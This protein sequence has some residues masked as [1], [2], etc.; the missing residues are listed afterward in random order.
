[1]IIEDRSKMLIFK[2]GFLPSFDSAKRAEDAA[3]IAEAAS[4]DAQGATLFAANIPA[5]AANASPAYTTGTLFLT[6]QE[7][8]AM[9]VLAPSDPR[10][11]L[12]TAGGVK[13]AVERWERDDRGALAQIGRRAMNGE[14]I[15]IAMYG[16]STV[17]GPPADVAMRWPERVGSIMRVVTKNTSIATYN[18]GVS[19]Q[20]LIDWWAFDNFQALVVDPYPLSE[21]V[22]IDFGLND[23]KTDGTGWDPALFKERYLYLINQVRLSGRIPIVM[24]PLMISGTLIRPVGVMQGELLNTVKELAELAKVDLVDFNDA[25]QAW[26]KN[27][28]DQHRIAEI[29]QDGTHGQN[30]LYDVLAQVVVRAMYQHM[31]VD[32]EHGTQLGQHNASFSAGFSVAF[33]RTINNAF[34]MSATL[35]KTAGDP[36]EATIMVWS[37]RARHAVYVS[38]DRSVVGAAP[39]PAVYVSNPGISPSPGGTV[40]FGAAGT[41]TADRP[42]E[43]MQYVAEL[44]FG[45]SLLRFRA[46]GAG[47]YEFGGWLIVDQFDSVSVAAYSAEATARQL[48]LP[49]F[50]DSRPEIVARRSAG[51]HLALVGDLPVGWGVVIGTQYVFANDSDTGPSRRKQ[52]IVVLRT[53][54]GADIRRVLSGLSAGVFA[55]ASIKTAGTGAWTGQITI[56]CETD[57]GGNAQIAVRANGTVI[58]RHT[59]TGSGPFMSPYG[60]MGGLYRD[61]AL[62]AD[63]AGRQA[64][65]T[66]VPMPA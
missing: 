55:A 54:D 44:P 9:R 59:N 14:A 50:W 32:V 49:E 52:S 27:R 4:I 40:T 30:A 28:R 18:C 29:Q 5:L 31:I 34:G 19:N 47:S 48:F 3:D 10:P 24:T 8:A 43:N 23:I 21:Y 57:A 35:T 65:A 45:I 63:P 38:P 25:M 39:A 64:V 53:A 60:R 61:P 12:V 16:D 42:A 11:H 17:F 6:R 46:A 51:A 41:D 7:G 56:H 2:G 62:V 20:K 33:N 37:D 22:M 15:R 58:A 13:L 36:E 26:Q 66:L 1:M